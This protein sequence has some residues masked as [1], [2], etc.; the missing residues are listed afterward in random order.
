[1][2]VGQKRNSDNA[3]HLPWKTIPMKLH[4]KKGDDEKRT[5]KLFLTKK[6]YKVR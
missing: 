5:G 6:E 2:K 4:L 3:T 1:M